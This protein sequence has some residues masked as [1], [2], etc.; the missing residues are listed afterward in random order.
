MVTVVMSVPDF[1]DGRRSRLMRV[2]VTGAS[3]WIGSAT[4]DE[5]LARGHEVVGLARSDASAASIE[6]KGAAVRRGDLD[7]LD[8]LRG[9]G[10]RRRRRHPPRQQARLERPGRVVPCG[11][12]GRRDLRRDAR[13]AAASRSCSPPGVAGLAP[14]RPSTE[15]DRTELAR[16][17][18]R[19]AAAPR[20]SPSTPC[21]RSPSV[22]LRF[23]PTVHG[24]GDHG[25]IAVIAQA[26]EGARVRRLHRRRLQR[27]GG[28]APLR[29]RARRG[30]RAG[31]GAGRHRAAHRRASRA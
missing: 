20:T 31:D 8:V 19:R 6:A 5:L 26:A 9:R 30:A 21:P 28:R 2:F 29:R 14:G 24:V 25:F 7:T 27:L 16:A 11:A 12:R 10:A 18:R 13:P 15:A 4:V 1:R 23:A 17:A 3:G 22:A